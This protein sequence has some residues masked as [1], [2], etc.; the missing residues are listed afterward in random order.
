VPAGEPGRL[1][2]VAGGDGGQER[3]MVVAGFRP[4]RRRLRLQRGDDE[5]VPDA[6]ER[7][8]TGAVGRQRVE[9]PVEGAIG[10]DRRIARSGA[11]RRVGRLGEGG[12]T[13]DRRGAV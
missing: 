2:L 4:L 3:A 11:G 8:A 12:E 7:L 13:T 10:E 6:G 9:R 5:A 1:V